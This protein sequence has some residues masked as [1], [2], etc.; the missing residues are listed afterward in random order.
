MPWTEAPISKVFGS[1]LM[2]RVANVGM[3]ILG[4]YAQFERGSKWVTLGGRVSHVYQSSLGRTLGGGTSEIQRNL[5]A[6]K[7]LGLPRG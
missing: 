5:I 7:G 6:T 4:P 1:E 3:Q 2:Q